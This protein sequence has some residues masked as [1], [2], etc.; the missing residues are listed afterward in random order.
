MDLTFD[1][2]THTYRVGDRVVP[3]VTQILKDVYPGVYDGI[4]QAVLDRK[5]RIGTAAHRCAEL[6]V[7]GRLDEA[8]IHPVV[9][10]YFDSWH[11]WWVKS[12][13]RA[14]D[15]TTEEQVYNEA[16][17]YC[18]TV[19]LA[20]TGLQAVDYKTTLRNVFTHP[21]QS[22][23]Y[24]VAKGLELAACLYL[25]GDGSLAMFVE[26]AGSCRTDWLATLR[27]FNIRRAAR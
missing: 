1:A 14:A 26:S 12:G 6:F 4:P 23:A 17:D 22:W 25:K 2:E 19:D 10:P 27:V 24:A 5:A 18:G 15:V 8:T 9:R 7:L 16:G 20:I 11:Q 3:S 13:L 21:I